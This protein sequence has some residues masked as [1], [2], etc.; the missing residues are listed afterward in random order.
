[1][2]AIA[3]LITPKPRDL[4]EGFMVRRA[5]PAIEKRAV[6]SFIFLD[7][8]GPADFAPGQGI[9]VRPHPHIGLA[10]VTY[11]F[12]GEIVH[13][14]SLGYVQPIRP[15]DVNWM[16]AGRGVTHSERTGDAVRASGGRLYGL[17]LWVALP[18]A[19]EEIAPS[20]AH[21][22]AASLPSWEE[23]GASVRVIL[24]EAFGRAS[25]VEILSPMFYVDVKLSDGAEIAA[26]GG[27]DERAVYVLEG[28]IAIDGEPV[29]A[30]MLAILSPDAAG[31]TALGDTRFVMLGGAALDGPR[32]L[33]WNFVS[34]DKARLEAAKRDWAEGKFPRVPGDDEFIPLPER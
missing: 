31:V 11:L 32:A 1:M 18:K 22:P 33:W 17:Q 26:P 10:T 25:P 5:L 16:V 20:F 23:N 6:S 34:S 9:D 21:H 4:G 14:D 24:G 13:R 8:M 7:Q 3:H 28:R 15:S 27:W 12:D 29:D 30:G 2:A 19:H